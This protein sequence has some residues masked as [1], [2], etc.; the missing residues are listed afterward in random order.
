MPRIPYVDPEKLPAEKRPLLDTLSDESASGDERTHSFQNEA[1]N[2]YRA[3][4]NDVDLLE[5]FQTYGSVVWDVVGLPAQER[6]YAILSVAYFTGSQYEWHQ[7]VRVALDEGLT[8]TEIRAIASRDENVLDAQTVTLIDYIESFVAGSVDDALHERLST[9]Y[10]DETILGIGMLAGNYLGLSHVL[11][12]LD[13]T[14]EVPF[15]GW[16]LENL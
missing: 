4:A 6:E 15:V 1:L 5:A 12:A 16:Q 3:M 9:Y 10:A 8:P 11:N 14:T 13:V 2:V 7:H